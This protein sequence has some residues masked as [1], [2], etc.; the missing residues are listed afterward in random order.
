MEIVS[1]AGHHRS[2]SF[3]I[4]CFI[5]KDYR[6]FLSKEIRSYWILKCECVLKVIRGLVR[7]FLSHEILEL[8]SISILVRKFKNEDSFIQN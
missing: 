8:E 4:F 5:F 2:R 7:S 6:N 1:S 3:V